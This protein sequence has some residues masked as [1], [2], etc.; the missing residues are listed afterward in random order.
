MKN[1]LLYKYICAI[2]LLQKS[3]AAQSLVQQGVINSSVAYRKQ[4]GRD[5]IWGK[6]FQCAIRDTLNAINRKV[7]YVISPPPPT[8][9]TQKHKRALGVVPQA[10]VPLFKSRNVFRL[11]RETRFEVSRGHRLTP[12]TRHGEKLPF[13]KHSS[14]CGPLLPHP[15]RA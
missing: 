10:G 15:P 7:R 13:S 1:L 3:L 11:S 8:I 6:I 2:A 5:K 14:V 12:P 4:N 9:S